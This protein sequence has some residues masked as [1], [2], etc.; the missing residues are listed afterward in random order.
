[1]RKA[2]GA[3]TTG[4]RFATVMAAVGALLISS[5]I[6]LMAA[7]TTA[8]AVPSKNV[9]H[10]IV[11]CHGNSSSESASNPYVGIS[12]DF[13]AAKAHRNHSFVWNG[14]AWWHGVFHADGTVKRDIFDVPGDT[15]EAKLAYCN[16]PTEKA[17]P[18]TASVTPVQPTCLNNN[19]ASYVKEGTH[20][21]TWAESAAPAPGTTI[22]VTA[23]AEQGFTFDNGTGTKAMEVTFLAA[24]TNC[25]PAVSPPTT[26]QVSPPKAPVKAHVKA[27]T[28]T[29]TVV[30]AGLVTTSADTG[31]QAGLGLV[32]A[33]LLLLAGAGGLVL[34]EGGARKEAA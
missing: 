25:T 4:H 14:D 32:L 18:A 33:G 3:R 15:T 10:K 11:T 26:P 16:A 13:H 20:V 9:D 23:T 29:P 1:M 31:A 7:P 24:Q 17:P 28:K 22:T 12:V 5:G 2:R 27:Q 30:H 21:A 34:V 6:A 19:V 8:S